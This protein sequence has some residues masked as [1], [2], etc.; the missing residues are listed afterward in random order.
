MKNMNKIL[1]VSILAITAVSSANAKIV[2][3]SLLTSTPGTY[4]STNT[5][6]A[7]IADAKKAGTDAAALASGKVSSVGT[8][9]ANGTISVNGSDVAVK[10]LK[11]AAYTESS[12]YATAAQGALA[13]TALQS[14]QDIS[15]KED[16][17]NKVDGTDTTIIQ[18][19]EH[20]DWNKYYPSMAAADALVSQKLTVLDLANSYVQ[21]VKSGDK[22]A[23]VGR[24]SAGNAGKVALTDL[25]FTSTGSGNRA[26]SVNKAGAVASGNTGIVTGGTV[27]SAVDERVAKNQGSSAANKAVITNGSGVITTGTITSGMITDGT[28]ANADIS[29]SAAISPSK[30]ATDA[31][32][33]F[34]SDTEKSTWNDKQNALAS[35]TN[36]GKAITTSATDGSVTYTGIDTTV[37]AS[38]S[39]LV[40]SGAVSSAIDTAKTAAVSG[41][42]V[43]TASG[44]GHVV[45]AVT[46]TDGKIAVT[47]TAGSI[48]NTDISSS[49]AISPSK[50]ATDA[51]NRFV[52]DTNKTTW[53][54]K[55]N[56]IGGTAGQLVATTSTA[57]TVA[58]TPSVPSAIP[59]TPSK[60][61]MFV[62]TAKVVNSTPTFYWEDIGR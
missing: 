16:K 39:N 12:A 17:S 25:T 52:T 35:S 9:S 48:T 32:N 55:Q 19:S 7:A 20:T 54:G 13:E 62:L 26:L 33:R 15:G 21:Q 59:E 27:Y 45:T 18:D 61:G 41:L 37:T 46:Q 53:N 43:S 28:I 14:H 31:S 34:V 40:T 22:T 49:A 8:G 44:D 47:K 5:V 4:T 10:G 42:D 50:I 6:Q 2:S 11:S 29:S 3:E 23:L 24:D 51:S 1:A 38:S 57:G 58:Y 36:K 60:D 30:I 56:A